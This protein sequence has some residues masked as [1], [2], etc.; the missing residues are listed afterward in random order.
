MKK[1]TSSQICTDIWQLIVAAYEGCAIFKVI[2]SQLNCLT[3]QVLESNDVHKKKKAKNG[4]TLDI[5][6]TNCWHLFV[7]AQNNFQQSVFA[8]H[9]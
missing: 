4:Y 1:D 9:N 3:W 8:M 5:A 2:Y 7:N 6:S